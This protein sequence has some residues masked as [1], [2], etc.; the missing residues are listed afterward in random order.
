MLRGDP[1]K[2]EK[3]PKCGSKPF[4]QDE[5]KRGQIQRPKKKY[6][7]FGSKQDYCSI[8]CDDCEDIVG[9][10][11]PKRTYPQRSQ[12]PPPP[13]GSRSTTTNGYNFSEYLVSKYKK[14][15][16]PIKEPEPPKFG[17]VGKRELDL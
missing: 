6:W 15:E 17:D 13:Q 11:S 2:F 8:I 12:R 3:C 14:E 5:F 16:K 1:F 10:E 9:Y 7:G 4:K